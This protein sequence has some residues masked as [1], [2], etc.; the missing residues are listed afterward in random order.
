[1]LW[2]IISV[3]VMILQ[4][5]TYPQTIKAADTYSVAF[6]GGLASNDKEGVYSS[7]YSISDIKVGNGVVIYYKGSSTF[8]ISSLSLYEKDSNN[9]LVF[10]QNYDLS[11]PTYLDH[12][13]FNPSHSGRYVLQANFNNP[14]MIKV[15][16]Y[17]MIG[18]IDDWETN[19]KPLISKA[20]IRESKEI[21]DGSNHKIYFQNV[22]TGFGHASSV[23][24]HLSDIRLK[25][26]RN[27]EEYYDYV[28]YDPL[29]D[30]YV[31]ELTD[32]HGSIE[33]YA[34]AELLGTPNETKLLLNGK[35]FADEND[36]T[37]DKYH[38]IILNQDD[39]LTYQ[40]KKYIPYFE[41]EYR[42]NDIFR[43]QLDISK[44]MEVVGYRFYIVDDQNSKHYYSNQVV[45][46]K[47]CVGDKWIKMYYFKQNDALF[48]DNLRLLY[49]DNYDDDWNFISS[50]NFAS[51]E[52]SQCVNDIYLFDFLDKENDDLYGQYF[53]FEVDVKKNPKLN[54]DYAQGEYLGNK[55]HNFNGG[56]IFSYDNGIVD[57]VNSD[58]LRNVEGAHGVLKLQF[59]PHKVKEGDYVHNQHRWDYVRHVFMKYQCNL[60]VNVINGFYNVSNED[61]TFSEKDKSNTYLLDAMDKVTI[62]YQPNNGYGLKE[63]IIDGVSIDIN[64]YPTSYQIMLSKDCNVEIIYER[65]YDITTIVENGTITP[66]TKVLSNDNITI[67]YQGDTK[68]V[69]KSV[70]VD[71][72]EVD[73][74]LC[75][76]QYTFNNVTSNHQIKVI[77]EPTYTI[78]CE[79]ENGYISKSKDDLIKHDDYEVFFKPKDG[80]YIE[81]VIVDDCDISK[82]Y[83][84]SLNQENI[85]EFIDISED[86]YIKVKCVPYQKVELNCLIL[87]NEIY[88]PN[89]NPTFIYQVEGTDFLNQKVER[90]Y[91]FTFDS[92]DVENHKLSK[93]IVIDDLYKGSYKIEPLAVKRYKISDKNRSN[94]VISY[95]IYD[96]INIDGS[97]NYYQ[98]SDLYQRSK[99]HNF[100]HNALSNRGD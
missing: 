23:S 62:N 40:V 58:I 92:N 67:K 47:Q 70:I 42:F 93:T 66:S 50:T 51:K 82:N 80:Y 75:S 14:N 29:Y 97:K 73:K 79:I 2:K 63:V 90:C 46:D 94:N 83:V 43:Y 6:I 81:S 18:S 19:S 38:Q 59:N 98:I 8:S 54:F 56:E 65:L 9:N 4:V 52:E 49:F 69:L 71:G 24:N 32:C 39:V 68:H 25:I 27:N 26:K 15:S 30:G 31:Y 36:L 61:I 86:H 53:Y 16:C 99:Y 96:I 89:G 48:A 33:I 55:S 57:S 22:V 87:D 28:A 35:L 12:I 77:Y 45:K 21:V 88:L 72:Y 20:N 91:V 34:Q 41:E 13:W 3:I 100:D 11:N 7:N 60:K 85:Y 78:N 10:I 95:S 1:M 74:N 64:K 5:L 44:L 37:S 76:N 84:E 17:N